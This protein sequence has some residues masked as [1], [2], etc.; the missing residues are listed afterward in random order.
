MNKKA[1]ESSEKI[2]TI[3]SSVTC[4]NLE[5]PANVIGVRLNH[6]SK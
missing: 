6:D 1:A 4:V 2:K 3:S 5:H